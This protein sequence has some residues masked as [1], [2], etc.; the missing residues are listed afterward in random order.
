MT[1]ELAEYSICM[2][3][4]HILLIILSRSELFAIQDPAVVIELFVYFDRDNFHR[5]CQV[6]SSRDSVFLSMLASVRK[7]L[8]SNLELAVNSS[9]S[10]RLTIV[11]SHIAPL[12]CGVAQMQCIGD[13]GF[14][15][16]VIL[17][18]EKKCSPWMQNS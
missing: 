13:Q 4:R 10:A 12:F 8:D 5:I 6:E 2:C 17:C 18:P 14:K 7:G 3:H 1:V 9:I 15:F 11:H 16:K